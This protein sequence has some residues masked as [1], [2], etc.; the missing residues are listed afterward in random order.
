V[1]LARA[2]CT[3]RLLAIAKSGYATTVGSSQE[4]VMW[5]SVIAIPALFLLVGCAGAGM[6]DQAAKDAIAQE[7]AQA[8]AIA[9]QDDARCQGFGAKPGSEAYVRC[10]ASLTSHRAEVNTYI[11]GPK[12]DRPK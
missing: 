6:N 5:R 10:R 9:Q 7:K 4:T 12:E 3:T 2:K 11:A 8:A 1:A